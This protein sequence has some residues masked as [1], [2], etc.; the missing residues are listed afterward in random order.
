MLVSRALSSV[1]RQYVKHAPSERGTTF[2]RRRT[3]PWLVARLATG[4]WIRVSGVSC[5]EW[6]VFEGR[7][8]PEARTLAAFLSLVR[9]GATVVDVGANIGL[10][11][12]SVAARVGPHGRVLALEPDPAAAR[13]LRENVE[14]NDFRNVAVVEAAAA[15]AGGAL[16]LQRAGDSECSSLFET[17]LEA[18]S[19]AVRATTIDAEVERA[20]LARVDLL[21]LDVEGAELR[22]LRG[23]ERL[24][25]GPDPPRL[26]V[27]ANPIT[28]R[29]AGT[30]V[31]DLRR[32]IE[33]FGYRI[34]IVER[35]AWGG[36]QTENWLAVRPSA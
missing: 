35:I 16:Q 33:S 12:L 28:L 2:L 9:P 13:R 10:Y 15:D 29:A 7:E 32:C 5:F 26:L 17:G 25:R 20:G 23:A 1:V 22:A 19:V 31:L 34:A 3:A 27:E 11:T 6:A 14:L 8:S 4:P 21:K 18:S 36:E 24:L 30:S